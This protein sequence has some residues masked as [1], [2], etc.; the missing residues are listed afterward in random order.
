MMTVFWI[1]MA[2]IL[3]FL[4]DPPGKTV[5]V[6]RLGQGD[7]Y[8]IQEAVNFVKSNREYIKIHIRKGEYIEKVF[9]DSL[10]EGLTLEGESREMVIIRYAQSRDIWRCDHADD[11]GAAVL[12]VKGRDLIFN[13]LTV[14]N[15]YGRRSGDSTILCPNHKSDNENHT[16]LPRYKTIGNNCHQFAFRSFPGATRIVWKN[17]DFISDGGDTV[18]PWDVDNGLYY[19]NNCSVSGHVDAWCPRGYAFAENCRFYGYNKHAFIWHDGVKDPASKSVLKNCFFDGVEGFA[20]GRYHKDSQLY[21]FDCT[22]SNRMADK[23]V[24][25]A[26]NGPLHHGHRV[27][28]KNCKK[29][30]AAYDWYQDNTDFESKDI[31]FH[32]VFGDKWHIKEEK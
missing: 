1:H 20:L 27:Y 14:I 17:C 2:T 15:D 5:V 25:Q 28:Y 13:N 12:N 7:F 10:M 30:G 26:G 18:S 31:N 4:T 8:T 11:Y 21:L 3:L 23:P 9:I 19:M 29:E 22:F 16:D 32:W 6:D 24:Y